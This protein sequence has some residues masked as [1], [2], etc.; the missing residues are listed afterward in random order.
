MVMTIPK[1]RAQIDKVSPAEKRRLR[2]E[3]QAEAR[4]SRWPVSLL[5]H[6]DCAIVKDKEATLWKR[7]N[8]WREDTFFFQDGD[9]AYIGRFIIIWVLV[10]ILAI[11][12]AG[13]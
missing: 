2:A 5:E 10:Y 8:R 3:I 13:A 1:I 4:T 7:F 11:T 9:E 6:L 12:L